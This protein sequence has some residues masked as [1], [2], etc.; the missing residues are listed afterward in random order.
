V[1]LRFRPWIG[2]AALRPRPI[3]L[4]PFLP[5]GDAGASAPQE[6]GTAVCVRA[7]GLFIASPMHDGPQRDVVVTSSIAWG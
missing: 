2:E 3:K 1:L 7:V 4:I 6:V 5:S